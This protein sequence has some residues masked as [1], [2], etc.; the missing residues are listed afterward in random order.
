VEAGFTECRLVMAEYPA[1]LALTAV[2]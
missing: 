2:H 1:A